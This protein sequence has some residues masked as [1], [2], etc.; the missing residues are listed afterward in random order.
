MENWDI[1]Y[2]SDDEDYRNLW[3]NWNISDSSEKDFV[4]LMED[5]GWRVRRKRLVSTEELRI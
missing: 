3:E 1:P 4:C 2:S 5:C